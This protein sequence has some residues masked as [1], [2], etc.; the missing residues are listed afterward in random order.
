MNENDQ[1][2]RR[3]VD[4]PKEVPG[5]PSEWRVDVRFAYRRALRVHV[6]LLARPQ[7][8]QNAID[9]VSVECRIPGQRRF[10]RR[11]CPIS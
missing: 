6:V 11:S 9:R 4:G 10:E 8:K 2:W 1:P 3:E 7:L 5:R